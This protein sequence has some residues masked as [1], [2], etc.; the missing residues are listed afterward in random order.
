MSL[1]A[2][3]WVGTANYTPGRNGKKPLAIVDH[4]TAG[5]FPGCLAWLRNSLAKASAHYLVTKAGKIYR[6][7]RDE[8]TAWAN[9][10]INKPHWQLYDGSNPNRY[11]LSIEHEGLAGEALTEEQYQATLWLHKQLISKWKIPIDDNHII[12]HYRLDSVNRPN[13]PGPGF[14]WQRLFNDLLNQEGD[15]QMLVKL[16]LKTHVDLPEVNIKVNNK[17]VEK[18]LLLNVNNQDIS[19]APVRAIAEALGAK[20][21]W[22]GATKTVLIEKEGK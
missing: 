16:D 13:C 3:E 2:I 6:L 7:V 8:D 12:G 5:L 18:G 21:G 19:Y 14:P 9:G 10:T 1:F 17:I 22:D 15:N 20:V 4:I 11:T